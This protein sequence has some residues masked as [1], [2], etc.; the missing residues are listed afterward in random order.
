MFGLKQGVLVML[1]VRRCQMLP[2]EI[3][4]IVK[5]YNEGGFFG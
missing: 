2:I 5:D 1:K 4:R 3:Y